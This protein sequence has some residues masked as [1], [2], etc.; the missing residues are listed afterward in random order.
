MDFSK[1]KSLLFWDRVTYEKDRQ[2]RRQLSPE[3]FRSCLPLKRDPRWR[4]NLQGAEL[5][6]GLATVPMEFRFF[7]YFG[8][9]GSRQQHRT[10]KNSA[11]RLT[12]SGQGYG[13][14][15]PSFCH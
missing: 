11:F 8:L 9:F 14:S 12:R 2:L 15:R 13:V 5:Q 3:A 7:E 10:T 4:T 6:S 1:S